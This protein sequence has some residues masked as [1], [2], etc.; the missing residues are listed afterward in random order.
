M[1]RLIPGDE[2][3]MGP[4]G[5]PVGAEGPGDSSSGSLL[6]GEGGKGVPRNDPTR[7]GVA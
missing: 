4:R 6:R 7:T 1:V 5:V 2:G 3:L